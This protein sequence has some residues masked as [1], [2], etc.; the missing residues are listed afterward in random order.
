MNNGFALQ[1]GASKRFEPAQRDQPRE[2]VQ[3]QERRLTGVDE[4]ETREL[5][6][7]PKA[8]AEDAKPLDLNDPAVSAKVRAYLLKKISV[9]A[10]KYNEIRAHSWV[11][12][13]KIFIR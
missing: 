6:L 11:L 10:E 7:D 3:T 4:D 8:F 5:S 9:V 12:A 2:L 13:R 1:G